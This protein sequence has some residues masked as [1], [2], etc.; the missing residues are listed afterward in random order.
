M[1]DGGGG[2]HSKLATISRW[3]RTTDRPPLAPVVLLTDVTPAPTGWGHLQATAAWRHHLR[4]AVPILP[5]ALLAQ[6]RHPSRLL[7]RDLGECLTMLLLQG[8]LLDELLLPELAE[9]RALFG[10]E[11]RDGVRARW[12]RAHAAAGLCLHH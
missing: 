8:A 5:V 6:L 10:G 11:G 7:G 9:L 4:T 1:D 2:D 12:R 3:W